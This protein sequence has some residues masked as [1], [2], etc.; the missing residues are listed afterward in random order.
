MESVLLVVTLVSLAMTIVL[1]AI[2]IRLVREERRRSDARVAV[3]REMAERAWQPTHEER[4][5][6]SDDA[7][8]SASPPSSV[9]ISDAFDPPLAELSRQDQDVFVTQDLFVAERAPSPWPKR[10]A[11]AAVIAVVFAAGGWALGSGVSL[12]RHAPPQA[13]TADDAG[14]SPL[15]LVS[16]QQSQETGAI[17]ISGLVHNPRDGSVHAKVIATVQLFDGDGALVASGR[18]P[19]DFT[20]LRP[21]DESPFVINVPI[22]T[23]VAKYRI[24]FRSEDGH[25]IG[26]VDRRASSSATSVARSLP[27]L[28]GWS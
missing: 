4:V 17:T 8:N 9:S 11:L 23:R 6:A 15:E 7:A 19:L 27:G 13:L 12:L 28:R 24:G 5:L 21:G 3:L 25:V 22:A 1:A 14:A 2:L 16:L 26:H 18:A 10:L 20:V